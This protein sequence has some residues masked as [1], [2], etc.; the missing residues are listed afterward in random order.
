MLERVVMMTQDDPR[1]TGSDAEA[2]SEAASVTPEDCTRVV[3]D[4]VTREAFLEA[5]KRATPPEDGF[6]VPLIRKPGPRTG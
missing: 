3:I 5:L 2:D 4:V 6:V 1:D